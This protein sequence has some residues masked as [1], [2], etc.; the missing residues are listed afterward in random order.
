MNVGPGIK[1]GDYMCLIKEFG[2]GNWQHSFSGSY[3]AS[4]RVGEEQTRRMS[5]SSAMIVQIVT[6]ATPSKEMQ[7][8]SVLTEKLKESS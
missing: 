7:W 3:V 8:D 6:V 4:V 5:G 1:L 2:Q